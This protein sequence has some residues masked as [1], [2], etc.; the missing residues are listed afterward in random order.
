M[1]ATPSSPP[2]SRFSTFLIE[3]EWRIVAAA[4]VGAFALGYIGFLAV[5]QPHD[6]RGYLRAVTLT[7]HLFVLESNLGP[8]EGL[9]WPLVIAQVLAPAVFG[10][11]AVKAALGLFRDEL[12]SLRVPFWR[13]HVVICGLGQKGSRLAREYRR[14]GVRVADVVRAGGPE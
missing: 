4:A 8:R 7:A 1:N 2:S 10:Y 13:D 9:I 14:Q 6:L 3:H 12:R 5:V 11:A